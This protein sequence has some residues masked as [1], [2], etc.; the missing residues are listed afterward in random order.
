[1][2]GIDEMPENADMLG[3]L[4]RPCSGQRLQQTGVEESSHLSDPGSTG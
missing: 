4:L 1:M 2:K 3:N